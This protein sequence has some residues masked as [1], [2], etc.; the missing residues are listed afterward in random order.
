MLFEEALQLAGRG[1]T[2]DV[3]AFPAREDRDAWA[4]DQALARYLDAGLPPEHIT[5]SSD[6]GGCLP[7]FKEQGELVQMDIG[8]PRALIATLGDLLARDLALEHVLPASTSNVAR[9]LRLHAKGTISVGADTDLVVLDE[10][11]QAHGVMARGVWHK[12]NGELLVRPKMSA[13]A[14]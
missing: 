14:D 10:A 4:A 1:C 5:I 2:I 3:T 6:G 8:K 7:V 9:L 11:A 12:L 13:L